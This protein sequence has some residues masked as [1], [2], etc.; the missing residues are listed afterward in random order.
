MTFPSSSGT[1]C[2]IVIPIHNA[3]HWVDWCIDEVIRHDSDAVGRVFVVDDGSEPEQSELIRHISMRFHKT[4]LVKTPG[5]EH[6]FGAACNYGAQ[7]STAPFLLFLNTD[8]LI[9]AGSI[10]S[11][12]AAFQ[13]DSNICLCSPVSNNSPDLTL[14]MFSGYSYV[15]MNRLCKESAEQLSPRDFIVDACTVVGNCLMVRRDF[16][17]SSGGFD[18]VWGKGY[19]EETDLHMK[20]FSRGLRGVVALNAYVYHYGSGTFR[21]EAEH[22]QMKKRNYALFMS[23]W[24]KE[25]RQLSQRCSKRPPIAQLRKNIRK[26]KLESSPLNLD[27]LFCLPGVSQSVGGIHVVVSLCNALIRAGI[28]ACCAVVGDIRLSGPN[29]YQEPLLFEFL[30]YPTNFHLLA[31]ANV[32]PRLVVSTLFK[33]TPVVARLAQTRRAMHV[34][35]VQ[36]YEAYFDA[37]VRFPEFIDSLKFGDAFLTTSCWLEQM[38]RRHLPAD[39]LLARVPLGVNEYIFYPDECKDKESKEALPI[40]G[41]VL[42]GVP[43]KGQGMVFEILD[44]LITSGNYR[45]V[46][47]RSASYAVPG[48]WPAEMYQVVDLPADQVSIAGYLRAIDIFIDASLHEGFGLMPLEALASGCRV[49]CSDSGGTRDFVKDGENGFLVRELADPEQYLKR[50]KRCTDLPRPKLDKNFSSHHSLALYVAKLRE[51]L[52]STTPHEDSLWLK[53]MVLASRP[54]LAIRL[55]GALVMVYMKIHQHVPPRIHLALAALFGKAN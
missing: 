23:K 25:Y 24:G 49:V 17:A 46:L 21:Y 7:H 50:I 45:I 11:L 22:S 27:V 40:V 44:R 20:A 14:P 32:L 16:F 1:T 4:V 51:F 52:A 33:S 28:R 42:R 31:D 35:F 34:Q 48:W 38:I 54:P 47:F 29:A 3:A 18:N 8:C 12:L 39:V 10:D 2:D 19:G 13:H 5:P 55:Y 43:D 6:G 37:G 36:G 15:E 53:Q 26:G 9:T 41:A 30:L